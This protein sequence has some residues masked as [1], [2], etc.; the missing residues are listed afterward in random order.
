MMT[1]K[2]HGGVGEWRG[3]GWFGDGALR[4][5][6]RPGFLS[7]DLRSGQSHPNDWLTRL[8]VGIR[9]CGHYP[10]V[11]DEACRLALIPV[12]YCAASIVYVSLQPHTDPSSFADAS[13]CPVYHISN[14]T[15]TP[16][17][18]LFDWLAKTH[19]S[20][21]HTR[22]LPTSYA[23]FMAIVRVSPANA[24]H[25]LHAQFAGGLPVE[26][27]VFEDRKLRAVLAECSMLTS[28]APLQQ[29]C[30]VVDE[31]LFDR[32]AARMLGASV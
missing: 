25:S 1:F 26:K 32:H 30:P 13:V 2:T 19:H 23:E 10:D 24:F 8:L 21:T 31:H 29:S 6:R 28:P 20:Q 4:V 17:R 7:W 27:C 9:Q 18:T 15:S 22:L 14:A 5:R 16:F 3:G 11:S 12:D